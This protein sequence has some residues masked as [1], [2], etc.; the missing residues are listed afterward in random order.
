MNNTNTKYPDKISTYPGEYTPAEYHFKKMEEELSKPHEGASKPAYNIYETPE[1]YKV[2]LAAPGLKRED[3]F[4]NIN[5]HGHLSISAL[6]QKPNP[7]G[8]VKYKKHAFN[9]ECFIR[10]LVLPENVD[11]DFIKAEYKAGILS[12]LFLKTEKQYQRRPSIIIVY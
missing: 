4:V 6:H 7:M 11:T 9:Y 2:E 5:V 10:K 1:Y 3:F 12:F 8:N